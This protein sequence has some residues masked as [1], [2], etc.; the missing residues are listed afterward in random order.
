LKLNRKHQLLFYAGD[1]SLLDENM[2]IV[3]K[4]TEALLLLARD[5]VEVNGEKSVIHVLCIEYRR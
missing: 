5:G 3:E 1:I 4:N 2:T